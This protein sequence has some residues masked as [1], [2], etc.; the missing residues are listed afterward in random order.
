MPRRAVRLLDE[1]IEPTVRKS[2]STNKRYLASFVVFVSGK[3]EPETE[4]KVIDAP[5]HPAAVRIARTMCGNP[6]L[7]PVGRIA[8][9]P[10]ANVTLLA[11]Q[12]GPKRYEA[13]FEIYRRGETHRRP[14]TSRMI[15]EADGIHQA[16]K[17]A[18]EIC[19]NTPSKVATANESDV[20]R[21][22][23]RNVRRIY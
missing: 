9:I 18:S 19:R 14:R 7:F 1:R 21:C 3:K 15:I 11:D 23:Q 12:K 5:N 17:M 22:P 8:R 6:M 4:E 20:V 2:S 10:E 16:R 13:L